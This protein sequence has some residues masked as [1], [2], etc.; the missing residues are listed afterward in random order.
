MEALKALA[1]VPTYGLVGGTASVD[2]KISAT[3]W[4]ITIVL[5]VI[6]AGWATPII[7]RLK[8]EGFN[9]TNAYVQG[10]FRSQQLNVPQGM[11]GFTPANPAISTGKLF[12]IA[13]SHVK[14]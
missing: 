4:L 12:N 3:F 14:A 10:A 1:A 7:N 6:T 8:K 13:E 2:N 5:L 9:G 11:S